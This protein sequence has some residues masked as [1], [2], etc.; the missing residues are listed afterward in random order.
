LENNLLE[1]PGVKDVNANAVT[2]RVLVLYEPGTIGLHV[3]S[4]I[5][6]GLRNL[7]GL[8]K[9]Q[10][11]SNGSALTRIIKLSVPDRKKVVQPALLSLVGHA[12]GVVLGLCFVGIFNTAS[13][14]GFTFLKRVGLVSKTSRIIFMSGV[15]MLLIAAEL[16]TRN[17]RKKAWRRLAL[18]APHHLRTA[19]ISQIKKQD[20]AFFDNQGTGN[21]TKLITEATTQIKT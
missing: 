2:G 9:R 15:S 14:E 4:L 12:V 3:E 8:T 21:L 6:D 5:K 20:K 7:K 16:F 19:L 13:G 1:Y 11:S 10:T 17:R 18:E